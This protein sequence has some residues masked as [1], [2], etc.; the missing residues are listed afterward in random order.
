MP[1]AS[2][3]PDQIE[4]ISTLGGAALWLAWLAKI[5][6]D[7]SWLGV[8]E[9]MEGDGVAPKIQGYPKHNKTPVA[10]MLLAQRARSAGK[11]LTL[12]LQT[13]AENGQAVGV[14][15]SASDELVL[16]ALSLPSSECGSRILVLKGPRQSAEQTAVTVKLC[17]WASARINHFSSR[18]DT[19]QKG[20]AQNA[21]SQI[22]RTNKQTVDHRIE[23][24]TEDMSPESL[25]SLLSDV[26]IRAAQQYGTAESVATA[27][28]QLLKTQWGCYRVSVAAKTNFRREAPLSLLAISDHAELDSRKSLPSSILSVMRENI[29]ANKPCRIDTV[30][31]EQ[32]GQHYPLTLDYWHHHKQRALSIL[33]SESAASFVQSGTECPMPVILLI[34][35]SDEK[36]ITDLQWQ[37]MH[38]AVQPCLYFLGGLQSRKRALSSRV[39]DGV[40]PWFSWPDQ[41]PNPALHYGFMAICAVLLGSS[42]IQVPFKVSARA[43]VEARNLQVLSAPQVGL[44]ASARVRAGDAVRQGDVLAT[45]DTQDLVLAANKWEAERQK[46]SQ[47]MD[48]ALASRD[49]VALGHLRADATRIKA[50]LELVERQVKRAELRAP[51]DGVVLTGDLSQRLGASV[52]RGEALFTVAANNE[53]NLVLNIQEQ[54]IGLIAAGQATRVRMA[55]LPG[56]AWQAYV[57]SVVPVAV[58]EEQNNIFR[59]SAQMTQQTDLLRPGMEGVAK[60]QIDRR[61]A[62]WVYT[63][64]LREKLRM[65]LW[66]I[67]MIT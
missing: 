25:R 8:I 15:N 50:E 30:A 63:R 41:H 26:A 53:F 13:K 61:A 47:A 19:A 31:A 62:L 35:N 1:P 58:P 3:A 39:I 55:A 66:R 45:L 29:Q 17:R 59:V 9:F 37:S 24:C 38:E 49:R 34:E 20:P 51:F 42:L 23:P 40:K 16:Q 32:M 65:L 7:K 36:G 10:A 54:D 57:E 21:D 5:L 67:G 6:P 56:K 60:V 27:I 48:H 12:S 52:V 46:N 64:S 2:D 33:T 18:N 43:V 44:V 28:S 22:I 4:R 14:S 11:V